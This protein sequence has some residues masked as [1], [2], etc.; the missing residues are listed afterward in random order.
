MTGLNVFVLAFEKRSFTK[1]TPFF[2]LF[3]ATKA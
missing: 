3:H 1:R 2:K